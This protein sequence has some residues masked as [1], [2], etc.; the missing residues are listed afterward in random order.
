MDPL[1]VLAKFETVA[2]PVP[3]IIAIGVLGGVRTPNPQSW[4]RG[5]RR[6]GGRADPL[7]YGLPSPKIRSGMV[8]LERALMSSYRLSVRAISFQDCQPM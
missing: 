6:V 2:L 4:G 7:P 1:N 8:P 3:Q 5:G